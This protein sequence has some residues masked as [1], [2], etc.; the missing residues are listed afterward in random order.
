[1]LRPAEFTSW[2]GSRSPARGPPW[3]R[4]IPSTDKGLS[5]WLTR[6]CEIS[7]C[8]AGRPGGVVPVSAGTT[9]AASGAR[10]SRIAGRDGP[11]AR[12]RP[13]GQVR[14]RRDLAR[15]RTAFQL[16]GVKQ[17]P[18]GR[19]V[20]GERELPAEVG[21]A[22]GWRRSFPDRSPGSRHGRHPRPGTAGRWSNLLVMR[23]CT[24]M[25]EDQA[26]PVIWRRNS[27]RHRKPAAGTGGPSR[28][29]AAAGPRLV[30]SSRQ[31]ACSPRRNANSK[32]RCPATTR[33][34]PSARSPSSSVVSARMISTGTA[35]RASRCPPGLAPYWPA[36]RS[37]RLNEQG[38]L[39]AVLALN[40]KDGSDPLGPVANF[41]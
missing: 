25:R 22:P 17:R 10:R 18:A 34:A 12:L 41:G 4:G 2:S 8:T 9:G 13:E 29:G 27:P 23:S 26:R 1:M 16:V 33:T 15:H 20:A 38:L 6:S 40:P 3:R 32:P 7:R 36:Y 11:G 5:R 14:H 30:A 28:P 21:R 31:G 37:L 19:L 24:L 35:A 39:A